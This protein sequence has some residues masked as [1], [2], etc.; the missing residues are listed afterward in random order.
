MT[1]RKIRLVAGC[2]MEGVLWSKRNPLIFEVSVCQ[3]SLASLVNY[4]LGEVLYKLG[5]C[6]AVICSNGKVVKRFCNE[7]DFHSAAAA[8]ACVGGVSSQ[9]ALH[10][11]RNLL[12]FYIHP[13]EAHIQTY[14]VL[15]K[16]KVRAQF[17]VP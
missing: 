2:K 8:L 7:G 3:R 5:I 12:V 4:N 9:A 15:Y 1:A 11:T 10:K 14:T 17:I 16:C 13:E 6:K